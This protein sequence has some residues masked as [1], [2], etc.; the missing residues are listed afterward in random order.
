MPS[1]RQND[2]QRDGPDSSSADGDEPSRRRLA[3]IVLLLA[4]LLG[5]SEYQPLQ[6]AGAEGLFRLLR[7]GGYVAHS[8]DTKFGGGL[9]ISDYIGVPDATVYQQSGKWFF[10]RLCPLDGAVP[11]WG[12][13]KWHRENTV[14]LGQKQVLPRPG[15]CMDCPST[16]RSGRDRWRLLSKSQLLSQSFASLGKGVS[17]IRRIFDSVK[18]MHRGGFTSIAPVELDQSRNL[19]PIGWNDPSAASGYY[20]IGAFLRRYCTNISN[21]EGPAENEQPDSSNTS[22]PSSNTIEFSSRPNL[23]FLKT[24]LCFLIGPIVGFPLYRRGARLNQQGFETDNKRVQRR[25]WWL[26][27]FGAFSILIGGLCL[28]SFF[29]AQLVLSLSISI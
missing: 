24:Y 5:L 17:Q 22:S 3:S 9:L 20:R 25:A 8:H 7:F 15:L 1:V 14:W 23:P 11:L 19:G 21:D 2:G 4:A 26:M 12:I 27:F 13:V 10:A 6:K 16:T 18:Q 28:G 29:L